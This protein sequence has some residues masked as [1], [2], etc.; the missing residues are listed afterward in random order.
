MPENT[1]VILTHWAFVPGPERM[2]A[3]CNSQDVKEIAEHSPTSI[4]RTLIGYSGLVVVHDAEPGW[5]QWRAEWRTGTRSIDLDMTLMDDEIWG[6]SEIDADCLAA[7][8]LNLW[9][10]LQE[11]H[12]GIW[13]HAPDC[14]M[15]TRQSFLETVVP[16]DKESAP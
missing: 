11:R 5:Y 15:H 1:R 2:D 9:A 16:G 12:R 14:T 13:L 3:P 7:D 6:G 10:L 8:I 4:A